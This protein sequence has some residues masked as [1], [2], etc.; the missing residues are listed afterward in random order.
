[1]TSHS[2][3]YEEGRARL[4]RWAAEGR[5]FHCSCCEQE[6]PYS[7]IDGHYILCG[8]LGCINKP[9]NQRER[10]AALNKLFGDM[11]ERVGK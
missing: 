7:K 5:T 9:M 2:E 1:M 3:T 4:E 8:Y 10:T 6:I 11:R